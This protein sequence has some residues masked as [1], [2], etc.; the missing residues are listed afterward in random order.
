M[1]VTGRRAAE[2]FEDK[3]MKDDLHNLPHCLRTTE[4]NLLADH[5]RKS[6][7]A[8]YTGAGVSTSKSRDFGMASWEDLLEKAL[9]AQAGTDSEILGML[10]RKREKEWRDEPWKMADWLGKKIGKKKL[11]KSL[12]KVVQSE[13]NFPARRRSMIEGGKQYK[14]LNGDFL[15]NAST[16]N[17]ICAFCATLTAE[18]EGTKDPTYRVAPNPRVYA[19]VTSN[20]D[21]FLEAASSNMFIRHRLKPVGRYGSSVG[22]LHQIPVFHIHGYVPYPEEGD[23]DREEAIP[24]M[25]DPVLTTAD[26]EKAWTDSALSFT[27]NPQIHI[28]R[29]YCTLFIGFSFRDKWIN[30]L[31]NKLNTE[32]EAR[33][34]DRLYHF[35]LIIEAEV[36][37][38]GR[39]FFDR[40]GVKPIQLGNNGEIPTVLNHLYLTGLA[41]DHRSDRIRLP[42]EAKK[43]RKK[44]SREPATECF[45][46][47]SPDSFWDHL[48]N[49]R[50]C[51]VR[52]HGAK[53]PIPLP[54]HVL[55]GP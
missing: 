34:P 32:R 24:P 52:K 39:G 25:V 36:E 50:N 9:V 33:G 14:Q 4:F 22:N 13:Q 2:G 5:Y 28:L 18:V 35:A 20:Y 16:L 26:Y 19:V 47:I 48:Y 7:I 3:V 8:L 55:D 49:C 6:P 46:T 45:T 37:K 17:S 23:Q 53:A 42:I 11:Q 38:R 51:A 21:P 27:M 1:A 10:R 54:F 15:A 29:H 44:A 41:E 43:G 30:D 31:L 12:V 40:L